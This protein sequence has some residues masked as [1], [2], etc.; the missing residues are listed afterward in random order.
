[1]WLNFKRTGGTGR[2]T[3]QTL[4]T[5]GN[6]HHPEKA[7]SLT[8]CV[9]LSHH[10]EFLFSVMFRSSHRRDLLT[11]CQVMTDG[12]KLIVVEKLLLRNF[13]A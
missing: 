4:V 6:A 11:Y 3:E 5:G 1:M 9:C 2:R 7:Q 12:A 8:V 13:E 10:V